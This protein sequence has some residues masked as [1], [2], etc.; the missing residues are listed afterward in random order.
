MNAS[1]FGSRCSDA[2]APVEAVP[3]YEA[4]LQAQ[5]AEQVDNSPEAAEEPSQAVVIEFEQPETSE[6]AQTDE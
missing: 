6:D 2:S 1:R 3:T 4:K 5:G